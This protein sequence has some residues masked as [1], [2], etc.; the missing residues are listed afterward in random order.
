MKYFWHAVKDWKIWVHMFITIG[1]DIIQPT[2]YSFRFADHT[3]AST[4][5]YTRSHSSYRPSSKHS[6][7]PM[8]KRNS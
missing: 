2:M 6:D 8:R 4:H 5:R 3:L 1:Y 7:I